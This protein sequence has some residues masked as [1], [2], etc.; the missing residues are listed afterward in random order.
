[1]IELP[2]RIIGIAAGLFG[3]FGIAALAAAA[4][5]FP[6]AHV[7]TAGLMLVLHAIALLALTAAGGTL[8]AAR[9]IAALLLIVG[10]ALFSGDLVFRALEGTRLFPYAAPAGGLLLMAGWLAVAIGFAVSRP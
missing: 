9:R 5:A 2:D 1:M 3:A 6:G 4:H 10:T 8:G 7:D